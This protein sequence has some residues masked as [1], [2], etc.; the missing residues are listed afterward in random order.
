MKNLSFSR[1]IY[2][3]AS[4]TVSVLAGYY[5]GDEL[6]LSEKPSEYIGVTFSIL[7]AT[8]FAVISIVGDPSML[9]PGNWRVAHENAKDI[10]KEIHSFNFLFILYILVLGLLVVTEIIE[11]ASWD[12]YYFVFNIFAGI[13][14]FAFL[15]SFGLPFSLTRIQRDRLN[16]EIRNRRR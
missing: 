3:F 4:L 16:Q 13:S 7:A 10:Q 2:F 14:T 9:I 11:F 1:I 8:L 6:R 12:S 15:A 5:W